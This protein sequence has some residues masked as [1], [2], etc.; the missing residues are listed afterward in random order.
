MV[1]PNELARMHGLL[2]HVT[3][4]IYALVEIMD[5]SHG[6]GVVHY[7]LHAH[8]IV[9][10]FTQ[11]HCPRMGIVDCGLMLKAKRPYDLQI[12][13]QEFLECN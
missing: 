5:V 12:L 4:I 1:A 3:S 13:L 6:A 7:D 11:D 8:N 2:D 10:D 9:L